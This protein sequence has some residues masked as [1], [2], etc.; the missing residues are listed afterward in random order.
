MDV[1]LLLKCKIFHAQARDGKE[2]LH[3]VGW[4]EIYIVNNF[5]GGHLRGLARKEGVYPIPYLRMI[6]EIFGTEP[7]TIEVCARTVKP[8]GVSCNYTIDIN[9][10]F[11]PSKV[12]DGQTLA[13]IPS[14]RWRRWRCDPPYNADTAKKMYST[15]LPDP[16]KLLQAAGSR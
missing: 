14:N 6:E 12:T 7:N 8:D 2:Y 5:I 15:D 16:Y 3:P 10:S 11:N 13:G 1:A 9:P 4:P